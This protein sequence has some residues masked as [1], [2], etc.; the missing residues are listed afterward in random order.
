MRIGRWTISVERAPRYKPPKPTPTP[1]WVEQELEA[2]YPPNSMIRNV[3][4]GENVWIRPVGHPWGSTARGV[5]SIAP[6][7]ILP[8]DEWILLAS[9]I[10][11]TIP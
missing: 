3:R 4:T 7:P 11:S 2:R 10:T 5:G 1:R 9:G 8:D 6:Q